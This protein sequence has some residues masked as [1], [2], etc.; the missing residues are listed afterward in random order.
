VDLRERVR[1]LAVLLAANALAVAAFAVLALTGHRALGY[2]LTTLALAGL[3]WHALT[4]SFR[5]T[6]AAQLLLAAG[7]LTDYH[8]HLRHGQT[9]V[10]AAAGGVLA[11]LIAGEPVI[12]FVIERPRVRVAHLPGYAPPRTALIDPRVLRTADVVVVAVAGVSALAGWSPWPLALCVAVV[13]AATGVV[14]LQATRERLSG[15]PDDRAL[16]AALE[17]YG[18]KFALHFTAP[19]NTEFHVTMW[20]PY[21]DRVGEPYVIVLR[22]PYAFEPISA[23]TRVP[24]VYCPN[25]S[26][27]DELVTPG[28]KACFYPNNGALNTHMVRLH[29]LTHIHIGHGDSDK[30][31]AFNPVTAMFDRIFVPGRAAIDRYAANGVRIPEEKFHIV[32]RPQAAGIQVARHEIADVPDKT[33]LYALTWVGLHDDLPYCSLPVADRIVA[34][35]LERK[36][37]VILRPHPYSARHPPSARQIARV[38]QLL[39]E[40]RQQTGREHV[41]GDAATA[42]TSLVECMNAADA[43]ISDVSAVAQD[44]LFSGKPLAL[45]D[46]LG[47]PRAEFEAAFPLARA[48]YLVDRGVD[49]LDGVLHD[50]LEA[51]PLAATRRAVRA[52]YLGDFPAEG[53]AD[54]FVDAVRPYLR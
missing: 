26:F 34:A 29:H 20:L 24:V 14:G 43:M 49:G 11:L 8:A 50:L 52:H 42:R 23:A 3:V 5:E 13:A 9:A 30:A 46:M 2:T 27:L 33:V 6:I 31:A 44:W 25:A 18:A 10:L 32:G 21:L 45:T 37:R 39:E 54:R 17:A 47:R 48:A 19:E 1:S 36:V 12:T 51:D 28:M 38:C 35:L 22:E 7:V 15:T 53:Y 40:D 16:R 41:F 4:H